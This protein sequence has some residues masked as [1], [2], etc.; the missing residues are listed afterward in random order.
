[1]PPQDILVDP[2]EDF[3]IRN[4]PRQGLTPLWDMPYVDSESINQTPPLKKEPLP[5]RMN[6]HFVRQFIPMDREELSQ[7]IITFSNRG[8]V[9]ILSRN[10]PT[11][12]CLVLDVSASMVAPDKYP[13]LLQAI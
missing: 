4:E 1:V 5:F 2:R 3:F 10:I 9:D 11:H 13:Y 6:Y 8:D 7:F 12:I